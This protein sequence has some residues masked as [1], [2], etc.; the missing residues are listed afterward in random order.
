MCL[1]SS[2]GIIRYKAETIKIARMAL[3]ALLK[4]EIINTNSKMLLGNKNGICHGWSMTGYLKAFA[5]F[6]IA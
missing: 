3:K 5:I 2:F 4:R 6:E 1:P